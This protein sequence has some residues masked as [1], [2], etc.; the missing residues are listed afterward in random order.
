MASKKSALEKPPK[1]EFHAVIAFRPAVIKRT[2]VGDG[3]VTEELIPPIPPE[4]IPDPA[5]KQYDTALGLG[6]ALAIRM[7]GTV[8]LFFAPQYPEQLRSYLDNLNR[9]LHSLEFFV[10][11]DEDGRVVP[12]VCYPE[13]YTELDETIIKLEADEAPILAEQ[14]WQDTSETVETEN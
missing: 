12:N 1:V 4:G 2:T 13:G 7:L 9:S 5:Q 10:D 11:T 14:E 3:T 6:Y 8:A